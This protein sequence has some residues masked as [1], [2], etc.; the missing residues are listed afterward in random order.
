MN[1]VP[2]TIPALVALPRVT[3]RVLL[4][5]DTVAARVC[6]KWGVTFD[7]VAGRARTSQV[8]AARRDLA[9]QLR[10]STLM[11]LT[12]IGAFLGNRDHTTISYLTGG[13]T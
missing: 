11:S 5:P 6:E 1:A 8:A 12:E 13:T 10:A 7:A 3:R 4:R 9:R 2:A